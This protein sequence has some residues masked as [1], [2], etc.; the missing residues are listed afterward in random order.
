MSRD[1]DSMATMLEK[2]ISIAL[3]AHQGQRDRYGNPYI[4]HP[5]H[6]MGQMDTDVE[7]M[8]AVLHDVVEDSEITISDLHAAGFPAQV[9]EAV[10]LLT[11]DDAHSYEEYV[12]RLQDN[13]LARKIKVA[14]LEHNMDLRRM[15]RVR[16]KDLSRL[17]KYRDAWS[18]LAE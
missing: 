6:L 14:D 13:D 8:A 15:D 9:T 18:I 2:A 3:Q 4:L 1:T 16:E 12:R 11:H 10:H 7:R 5:L 17:Q